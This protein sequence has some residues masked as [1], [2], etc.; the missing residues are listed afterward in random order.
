VLAAV[1][2]A[3]IAAA[4]PSPDAEL[5]AARDM[6]LR[7]RA[8][9]VITMRFLGTTV[10]AHVTRALQRHNAVG[11]TL[12]RDNAADLG[13]L[14]R[15]TADLQS[16]AGGRALIAADQE[17]GQVRR[18]TWASPARDQIRYGTRAAA[19]GA[20]RAAA[21]DLKQAGLNLNLAPVADRSGPGTLMDRRA[22]PGDTAHVARL[23]A[24]SVKAYADTGVAPTLK[25]FP[26][27]GA[28]NRNTDDANI[29]IRRPADVIG[30]T[31]L[32]PFAAGI[33]AGAPAVM[34]SHGRYPS[35]DPHRIA[36]QSRTIVTEL[37]KQRMGFH[38]VVMTDSLE[39]YSVRSRMSMETAAVRSIKAGVDLVLTTGQATHTQVRRALVARAR[40]HARFRARLT[41]AAARVILLQNRLAG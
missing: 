5:A 20:A 26:G 12:F 13:Q 22:F 19:R 8:G 7:E 4:A 40:H 6:S 38:G 39:A 34:V 27:L 9:T 3:V 36:S 21:K 16:A 1:F 17:G 2:G 37:L 11:V 23:V 29:T 30:R 10:P 18:L 35:L 31:D 24:A 25:H 41:D 15:L 32:P 14:Q 33:A 28:A